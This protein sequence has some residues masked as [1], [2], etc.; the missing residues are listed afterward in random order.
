MSLNYLTGTKKMDFRLVGVI[1]VVILMLWKNHAIGDDLM[2][3]ADRE[4]IIRRSNERAVLFRGGSA[5][6]AEQLDSSRVEMLKIAPTNGSYEFWGWEKTLGELWTQQHLP[7]GRRHDNELWDGKRNLRAR[8][9]HADRGVYANYRLPRRE[10]DAQLFAGPF[11]S[12]V[13]RSAWLSNQHVKTRAH[14]DKSHNLLHQMEGI[15]EVRVWHSAS[16]SLPSLHPHF[17][18]LA[19]GQAPPESAE[20]MWL[21]PGETLWLP[22]YTWHQVQC[23]S[24]FCFSISAHV[25]S[26]A[27][28]VLSMALTAAREASKNIPALLRFSV[29]E[30]CRVYRM[31]WESLLPA[32]KSW[33]CLMDGS[34]DQVK[35]KLLQLKMGYQG[36]FDEVARMV[37]D[38]HNAWIESVIW[39]DLI[40]VLAFE[41]LESVE[42]VGSY[43]RSACLESDFGE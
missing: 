14:Y 10:H 43:L 35:G 23:Q 38:V 7:T 3:F 22:A 12:Q 8:I 33:A 24:P 16:P 17:R 1:A 29:S 6:L 26:E 42:C 13:I 37:S 21:H 40:E 36:R 39:A 20:V 28:H 18:Q 19:E 41:E 11:S 32:G 9:E 27:E 34:S 30:L 25:P 2:N 15:K 31:R 5:L 4:T